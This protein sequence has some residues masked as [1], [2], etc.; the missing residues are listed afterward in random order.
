VKQE[1]DAAPA[2]G[3][4][5]AGSPESGRRID[6]R[7]LRRADV[8]IFS[9]ASDAP[10]ARRPTDVVLLVACIIGV[11]L[12]SIPAPGPTSL[13]PAVTDL[14]KQLPGLVGWFW[15]ISYNLLIGW[16]FVL[17]LIALFAHGRKRLF[18]HEVLAGFLAF[19]FAAFAGRMSGTQIS[20]SFDSIASAQP[21][22][23]YLAVRL[24]IATAIVVMASPH[25]SRPLRFVGRWVVWAGAVAGIALG[26]TL[27]IGMVAG[28]L[29]GL[30]SAAIVH[31]LFG[32]PAGRLT[33]DQIALALEDLEVDADDLRYAP[34][35][36]R[37]A[38]L[39]LATAPDGRELQVKVY[40]RDARD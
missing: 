40:G 4:T 28:L 27:P 15:Q 30:A 12:L 19:G 11:A 34:L 6:P 20:T 3:S 17:L 14:V 29:I 36:P 38:A 21:P 1:E 5:E 18:F 37:G 16:A 8:R 33:L 24:A 25:M 35:E 31:L 26:V 32:S 7:R 39:S 22:A 2:A 13:D 10:L 9:S 23:V